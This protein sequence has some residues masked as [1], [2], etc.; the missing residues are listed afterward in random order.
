MTSAASP[1]ITYD[2]PSK[3]YF[4]E[5]LE[6]HQA[7]THE[8]YKQIAYRIPDLKAE[9]FIGMI[10]SPNYKHV[11][12]MDKI[13]DYARAIPTI[14]AGNLMALRLQ[15]GEVDQEV[16]GDVMETI[17]MPTRFRSVA[18]VQI[19]EEDKWGWQIP[20]RLSEDAAT[21]VRRLFGRIHS[22]WQAEEAA[23]ST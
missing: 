11:V 4:K 22:I 16:M 19:E 20:D 9:N 1:T 2:Q 14:D 21:E 8:I 10:A 18:D 17:A 6:R 12:P 5:C 7:D 15:E 23:A 13:G 3:R